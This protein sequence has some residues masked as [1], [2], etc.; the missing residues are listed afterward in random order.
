MQK[1]KEGVPVANVSDTKLT[2]NLSNNSND[3][4]N[5]IM[6]TKAREEGGAGLDPDSLTN[7]PLGNLTCHPSDGTLSDIKGSGAL[8]VNPFT[9][10]TDWTETHKGAAFVSPGIDVSGGI[11]NTTIKQ[12][13]KDHSDA[14]H[15]TGL[16]YIYKVDPNVQPAEKKIGSTAWFIAGTNHLKNDHRTKNAQTCDES[17]DNPTHGNFKCP[18]DGHPLSSVQAEVGPANKLRVDVPPALVLHL[19][20]DKESQMGLA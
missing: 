9:N 16:P 20:I 17:G 6:G 4:A 14:L 5:C 8:S 11:T 12:E 18:Y 10:T 13:K 19:K 2:A 15:G 3:S 7:G 1:A